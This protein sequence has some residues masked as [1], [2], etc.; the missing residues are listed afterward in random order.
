MSSPSNSPQVQIALDF[1][2]ANSALDLDKSGSLLTDDFTYQLL[3]Q[4]L[5]GQPTSKTDFLNG[6]AQFVPMFSFLNVRY[7]NQS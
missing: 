4:S 2:A 6:V 3:P 7:Y 1:F 5:N